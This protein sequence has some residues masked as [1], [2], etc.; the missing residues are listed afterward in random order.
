MNKLFLVG[1]IL[2]SVPSLAQQ[3]YGLKV[4]GQTT[5]ITKVEMGD[6]Q[7]QYGFYIG[8][9]YTIPLK[10]DFS[11]QP[12]LMYSFQSFNN[13]NISF[14]EYIKQGESI[15]P[16]EPRFDF[17]Y[18]THLIKLP[19]LLK[20]QPNKVYVEAGPELAYLLSVH[21]KYS[22]KLNEFPSENGKLDDIKHFQAAIA[23]GGGYKLNDKLEA[24]LRL[25]WGLTKFSEYSYIKNFNVGIG[26]SYNLK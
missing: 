9:F 3:S 15:N 14:I 4:G 2:F 24:G 1:A 12:E 6:N 5:G 19:L 26:I 17:K 22:D 20:Y 8:G 25:S 10:D 23:V 11:F 7:N 21:G 18:K 13:V 16:T